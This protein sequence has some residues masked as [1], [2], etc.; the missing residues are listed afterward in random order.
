MLVL[1]VCFHRLRTE[2]DIVSFRVS[3]AQIHTVAVSHTQASPS[4]P[5][6]VSFCHGLCRFG[7]LHVRWCSMCR[8]GPQECE[9]PF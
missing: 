7:K 6:S 4:I 3:V 9:G 1:S 8:Y 5:P 2:F